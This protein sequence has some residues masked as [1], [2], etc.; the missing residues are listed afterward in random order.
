MSVLGYF[1]LLGLALGLNSTRI[2]PS[3]C[4]F[5][6]LQYTPYHLFEHQWLLMMVG[7]IQAA[8]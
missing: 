4:W 2:Y 3:D 6:T 7:I 8:I 1:A 5:T